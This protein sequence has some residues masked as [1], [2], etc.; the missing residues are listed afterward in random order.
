MRVLAIA[1]H[2]DDET[3]GCGGTLLRHVA[4]GD[5]IHW[6]LLT[7]AHE[8][9]FSA[10]RIAQQAEQVEA[11]RS[12]YPFTTLTWLKW[13][14]TRLAEMPFN[15]L[16]RSMRGAVDALK[17]GLVYV[18]NRSDVHS[19]H[20]VASQV[21]QSVTKSFYMRQLGIK[22]ILACEVL[23][24]TDGAPAL[25]EN[26]FLANIY[27]DISTTARQKLEIM[28]LFESEVHAGPMPRGLSAIEA[29]ARF[30]GATVGVEYAEAFMLI[31]EIN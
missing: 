13:P 2:P 12:A 26:M 1:V 31:R 18:P 28:R 10:A 5:E 20:R 4:A 11:V 27:H 7:S 6:L 22:R 14:T 8:P 17:P 21:V 29:L 3:L 9:D 25:P 15:E 24:E 23:S 16:I 19:D 30:R